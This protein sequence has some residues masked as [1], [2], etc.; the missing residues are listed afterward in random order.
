MSERRAD[1][2]PLA[3][4]AN[5]S[6]LLKTGDDHDLFPTASRG[7]ETSVR[8][9]SAPQTVYP[10]KKALTGG[11]RFKPIDDQTDGRRVIAAMKRGT[12][13]MKRVLI[14]TALIVTTLAL[15]ACGST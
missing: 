6:P 1:F 9:R 11:G 12:T 10:S 14:S 7:R 4:R 8:N 5:A 3:A 15:C 2:I 13:V